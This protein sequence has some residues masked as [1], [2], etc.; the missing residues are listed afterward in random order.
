MN[1]TKLSIPVSG[2][3]L[4]LSSSGGHFSELL[5]IAKRFNASKESQI[6]TFETSDTKSARI[7]F[8]IEYLPYVAPRKIFPLLVTIPRLYRILGNKY[9]DYIAST[10]AAIAIIG[11]LLARLRKKP[12]YYVES[13]ARQSS[14]SLTAKILKILGL[15]YCFVQSEALVDSKHTLIPN[16]IANFRTIKMNYTIEKTSLRIFV[17]LGTIRDYE[18]TRA[19]DLVKKI[20]IKTDT[21]NW[22]LGFTKY[23]NLPGQS[24]FELNR[25]QFTKLIELSDIVICHA[26]I[27]ILTD[28]FKAGKVPL[29]IPRRGTHHE[30][31]DDHQVEIMNLLLSK[32]LVIDLEANPSRDLFND[33]LNFKILA[34]AGEDN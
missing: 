10:G 21:V 28:C 26:G 27:G 8:A 6:L 25:D 15:K 17:A 31:V 16:P 12:F 2:C 19:I 14:L 1:S 18:F 3:G 23:Q 29:V 30:H 22:Q 20:I 5:Y 13:I 7:E 11:Y 9:F 24:H 33:V 34:D 32:N 4:F